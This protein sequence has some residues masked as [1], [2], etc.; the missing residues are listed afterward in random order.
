MI[1]G[2]SGYAQSGKDT[3]AE[4]LCLNYDYKRVSFADPMRQALYVLSPKLDNIV[5]LSE[6]V[7]DYVD[8]FAYPGQTNIVFDEIKPDDKKIE[9][10]LK[11]NKLT[12]NAQVDDEGNPLGNVV[13]SK[14]GDKMYK[15]YIDNL[16]GAE[17]LEASYKRQSQP[18]D[19]AGKVTQKGKLKS[20]SASK[21]QKVLDNVDE[22]INIEKNSLLNEEMENM[23]K[24]IGYQYKK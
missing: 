23:K 17:Q 15:N 12:G 10:Y 4:L 16:Y 19:I 11:G 2:L 22:S 24:L 1:V 14:L 7:D 20:S 9:M 5:R 3:V 13:P 6:Y 21:A 18:V 8:A